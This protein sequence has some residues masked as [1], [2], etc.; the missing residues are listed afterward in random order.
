MTLLCFYAVSKSRERLRDG[1]SRS[2]HELCPD[3]QGSLVRSLIQHVVVEHLLC[4]QRR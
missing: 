2:G 4:A 3:W 1:V